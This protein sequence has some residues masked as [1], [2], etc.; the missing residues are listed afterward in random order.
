MCTPE[1]SQQAA[2]LKG[3]DILW[4]SEGD[5]TRERLSELGYLAELAAKS[6]FTTDF[7]RTLLLA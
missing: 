1:N 2:V 4:M 7:S 6:P 3:V 5:Y